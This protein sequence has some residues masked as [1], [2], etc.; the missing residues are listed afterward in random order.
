MV[1]F[2]KQI[3]IQCISIAPLSAKKVKSSYKWEVCVCLWVFLLAVLVHAQDLGVW[4]LGMSHRSS[5]FPP[6]SVGTLVFLLADL[7][8]SCE[9]PVMH[10]LTKVTGLFAEFLFKTV[11]SKLII[12][13]LDRIVGQLAHTRRVLF[14]PNSWL[15]IWICLHMDWTPNSYPNIWQKKGSPSAYFYFLFWWVLKYWTIAEV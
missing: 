10:A 4:C 3:A 8:A 14:D 11:W 1:T 6:S 13:E 2:R 9:V 5:M 7:L 15:Q 12:P